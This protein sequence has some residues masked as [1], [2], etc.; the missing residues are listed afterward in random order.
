M[1]IYEIVDERGKG[2]RMLE[3]SECDFS[4]NEEQ[5]TESE[6]FCPNC[7]SRLEYKYEH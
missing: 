2:V 1:K 6:L 7:K 4:V 5:F 3:C